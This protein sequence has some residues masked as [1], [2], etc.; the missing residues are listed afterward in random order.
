M[1]AGFERVCVDQPDGAGGEFH[2]LN[3]RGQYWGVPWAAGGLGPAQHCSRGV[4]S[5]VCQRTVMQMLWGHL[6]RGRGA[7]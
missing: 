2:L 3:E 1:Y 6:P 7:W 5:L 4:S